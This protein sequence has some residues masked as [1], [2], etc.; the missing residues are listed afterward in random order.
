M[1]YRNTLWRVIIVIII[2]GIFIF[3]GRTAA[4][5]VLRGGIIS[6]VSPLMRMSAEIGSFVGFGNQRISEDMAKELV[7]ENQKLIAERF[8]V[9]IL[10]KENQELRDAL[11]F[12]K[13]TGINLLSANVIL[14][15]NE[16]GREMFIVEGGKEIG[17]R[18]GDVAITG[19]RI[20]VGIVREAGDGFSKIEIASNPM[21]SHEVRLVP[22]GVPAIA[23][24]LG[25]RT[26]SLELIPQDAAINKGDLAAVF[27]PELSLQL[28]LAKVTSEKIP[29]SSIFQE[30]RAVLIARPEILETVF[31][32]R[33][34]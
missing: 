18:D 13:E 19:D 10:Q 20:L 21:L 31:I 16:L 28:L 22:L 3:L 15:T 26:F 27:I 7:R 5:K 29:S 25:G 2:I 24:G 14:F 4:G 33:R 8:E 11:Q 30:A 6:F 23:K 32:L 1:Y 9:E 17:I 12:K 34:G